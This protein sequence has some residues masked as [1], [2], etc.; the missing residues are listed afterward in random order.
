MLGV[1]QVCSSEF[2]IQKN[3]N[4]AVKCTAA[5][6]IDGILFCNGTSYFQ[7][8]ESKIMLRKLTG[9]LPFFLP[10]KL[11]ALIAAAAAA[12]AVSCTHLHHIAFYRN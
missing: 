3:C 5:N 4:F 1:F 6:R 10:G 7:T 12:A 9:T 8:S 11:A 2:S